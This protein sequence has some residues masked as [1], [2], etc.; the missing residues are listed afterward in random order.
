VD[1]A[2]AKLGGTA[3]VLRSLRVSMES[4]P[5]FLIVDVQKKTN[6]LSV[7]ASAVKGA[8]AL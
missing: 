5:S 2:R 1:V 7:T 4:N 6:R 8:F 3:V